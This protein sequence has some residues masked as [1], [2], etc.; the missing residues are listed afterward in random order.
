[1]KVRTC[2]A[3]LFFVLTGSGTIHGQEQTHNGYWW[4]DKS[5]DFKLGF[6]SGYVLA[7]VNATDAA[8]FR[9]L[10][11]NNGGTLPTKYPGD[12][13]LNACLKEAEATTLSF[14]NIPMGQLVDGVNE[15]Y[16][17]FR[18]KNLTIGVAMRYARDAL[19]GKTDKE[20]QDELTDWRKIGSK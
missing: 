2:L 11:A 3:V 6:A 12:E 14:N 15:F 17:D 5:L 1:M 9:C 19:K 13:A 10:A 18:N 7:M 16:K 20:L 8:A 4:V